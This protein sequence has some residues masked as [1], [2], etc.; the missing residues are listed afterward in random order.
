M[1]SRGL[2]VITG[3][4]PEPLV[5]YWDSRPAG[6]LNFCP[7]H[8]WGF[9]VKV[10]HWVWICWVSKRSSGA[11]FLRSFPFSCIFFWKKKN[12][13]KSLLLSLC[14]FTSSSG[15]SWL[16]GRCEKNYLGI[17]ADY[18]VPLDLQGARP[19]PVPA[20]PYQTSHP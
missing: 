10:T 18:R 17:R 8:F 7:G 16:L 9:P 11:H 5:H 3:S 4:N 15:E 14:F 20:E 13:M 19:A 2:P 12:P 1:L 6:S